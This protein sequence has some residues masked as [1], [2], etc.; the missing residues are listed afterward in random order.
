MYVD[1]AL[2]SSTKSPSL[3]QKNVTLGD[4]EQYT[5]FEGNQQDQRGFVITVTGNPLLLVKR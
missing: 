3:L 5:T 4:T 1:Q 2:I